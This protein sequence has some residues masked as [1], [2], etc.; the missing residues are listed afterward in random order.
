MAITSNI[1]QAGSPVTAEIIN[2]IVNDLR[3]LSEAGSPEFKL[4][5]TGANAKQDN[6][7][8]SQKIYSKVIPRSIKYDSKTGGTWTFGTDIKFTSPPRCWVQVMNTDTARDATEFEF[9]IVI[10][11]YILLYIFPVY[12]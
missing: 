11:F 10:N 5:L 12:L 4:T 7:L 2:S 8:V 3:A 6:T 1:V 9:N